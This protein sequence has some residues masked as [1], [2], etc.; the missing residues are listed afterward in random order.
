MAGSSREIGA[1]LAVKPKLSKQ[2][3]QQLKVA[4][5]GMKE[6]LG[7]DSVL[8]QY[9]ELDKILRSVRSSLGSLTPGKGRLHAAG[10]GHFDLRTTAGR[11]GALGG[12]A[13]D[14]NAT[15]TAGRTGGATYAEMAGDMQRVIHGSQ[16]WQRHQ[17]ER[18]NQ[19][20]A[21]WDARGAAQQGRRDLAG[22]QLGQLGGRLSG[23]G[24][25]RLGA[26]R[27]TLQLPAHA[28]AFQ[29]SAYGNIP[30]G[31]WT[32][33]MP[34][35]PVGGALV[36]Y[37]PSAMGPVWRKPRQG[38]PGFWPPPPSRL[39]QR[40]HAR[41][42]PA[43]TATRQAGLGGAYDVFPEQGPYR[44]NQTLSSDS[45][46]MVPYAGGGH[47]GGAYDTTTGGGGGGSIPYN[48]SM[49]PLPM[50]TAERNAATQMY[51]GHAARG[52]GD[53]GPSRTERWLGRWGAAA[54]GSKAGWKRFTRAGAITG[55]GL[56]MLRRAPSDIMNIRAGQH[57]FR[58]RAT[59]LREKENAR[60][61][62]QHPIYAYL[63]ENLTSSPDTDAM[64]SGTV[65]GYAFGQEMRNQGKEAIQMAAETNAFRTSR[66]QLAAT[67]GARGAMAT[68]PNTG[69]GAFGVGTSLGFAPDTTAELAAEVGAASVGTGQA[70]QRALSMA[71]VGRRLGYRTTPF[72]VAERELSF[73]P[74]YGKGSSW[75]RRPGT[76]ASM[77][78]I[79]A[80][81]M[82]G[83]LVGAERFGALEL[84]A[85]QADLV[86]TTGLP[87]PGAFDK[88]I[89]AGGALGLS[90]AQGMRVGVGMLN[91]ARQRSMSGKL[92]FMD[93]QML[94]RF[95][96]LKRTGGGIGFRE[97]R[98]ARR[99]L[100]SGNTFTGKNMGA[101]MRD[102]LQVGG[103]LS[104]NPEMQAGGVSFLEGQFREMGIPISAEQVDQ[105]AAAV[106]GG[107]A[108]PPELSRS[109]AAGAKEALG[110][111]GGGPWR[112][113]LNR[114]MPGGLAGRAND[115]TDPQI[116]G[117]AEYAEIRRQ[118]GT[119]QEGPYGDYLGARAE[120]A[121][122]RLVFSDA[123]NGFVLDLQAAGKYIREW[124][125]GD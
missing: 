55:A 50:S 11:G 86:Q 106:R 56:R 48:R 3:L 40:D 15:L 92:G 115:V 121:K 42:L 47:R 45:T 89:Q 103:G 94:Q 105:I 49:V 98:R 70:F 93:I 96:G 73:R 44:P 102:L 69:G 71:Q 36:P 110:F 118:G 58:A 10:G 120:M 22:L 104:N 109:L 38:A 80:G 20:Q 6:A 51:M 27:P 2:D 41:V 59:R 101:F 35:G 17:G 100:Q 23:E 72:S 68:L 75:M 43:W 65:A 79:Y 30:G 66:M 18:R 8:K 81:A 61:R 85:Q 31:T 76:Q 111:G 33:G 32:P 87:F 4:A 108:L 90:P 12:L 16:Q 62:E 53:S 114:Q 74:D 124:A 39:P 46:A 34:A 26:G 63:R 99:Q 9:K 97:L 60:L 112:M 117:E 57:V 125:E 88:T 25:L 13:Q 28:A 21:Q 91:A 37:G 1:V 19:I 113:D 24:P 7:I 54:E 122:M 84:G 119:A 116:R 52:I 107:N 83:G 82:R 29:A 123:I 78:A 77:D 14:F 95:G 64:T 67:I 5:K